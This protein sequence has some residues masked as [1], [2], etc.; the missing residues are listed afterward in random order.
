MS[1]KRR[2]NYN[3][4]LEDQFPISNLRVIY[5]A[6]GTNVAAVLLKDPSGV[7]DTSL[8]YTKVK[9]EDEGLYLEAILNSDYLI[10]E[11]RD[12]QSQ[13]QWGA[14]HIH[15]HLLKPPIPKYSSSE[16]LHKHIVKQAKKIKKIMQNVKLEPDWGFKKCRKHI[17]EEINNTGDNWSELNELVRQLIEKPSLKEVNIKKQHIQ[18]ISRKER[19]KNKK[20][21]KQ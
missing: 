16:Q 3:R 1:F 9:N 5:T 18:Q 19:L 15:R 11:I 2:I 13:G 7:I 12:S 8:Y 14:R 20:I 6:S 21:M 10:E 4:T 17:R